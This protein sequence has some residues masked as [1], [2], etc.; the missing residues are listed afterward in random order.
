MISVKNLRLS[1]KDRLF[2]KDISFKSEAKFLA[3]LGKNGSSKSLFARSFI[4]L[5]NKGFVLSADEFILDDIKILKSKNLQELRKNISLVF[6]DAR[7]SFHPLLDVGE[8]FHIVLKTHTRLSKKDRKDLAFSLF[9][10]L[11]LKD[12]DRIWHSL[13]SQLSSGIAMRVEFALALALKPK[14]LI[15]DEISANLDDKNVKIINSLLKDLKDKGQ[16]MLLISHDL[17]L[18]K[19]LAD[20]ILF[21]DEGSLLEHRKKEDFFK[22]PSSKLAIE[23]LKIHEALQCF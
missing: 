3:I 8:Y 5:F 2:L 21:F 10:S 17:N 15:C 1:F 19:D 16:R 18:V 22:N 4:R 11:N 14:L 6:Q 20:E 12:P 7:A 13:P 23:L 9:T